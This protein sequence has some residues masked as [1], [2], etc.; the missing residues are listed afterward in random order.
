M[1]SW[2]SWCSRAFSIELVDV[3]SILPSTG[4][5]LVELP[6]DEWK[7]IPGGEVL[8][9]H[10]GY[11]RL[12]VTGIQTDALVQQNTIDGEFFFSFLFFVENKIYGEI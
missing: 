1:S 9:K 10:L 12:Q 6:L 7:K 4:R 11:L 3:T 5:E 2:L 8:A